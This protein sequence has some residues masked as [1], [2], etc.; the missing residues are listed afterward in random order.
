MRICW[1]IAVAMVVT[2]MGRPPQRTLLRRSLG[3]EGNNK[4]KPARSSIRLV[5]EIPVI[6]A[7]DPKHSHYIQNSANDPIEQSSSCP[8]RRERDQVHHSKSNLL[9]QD[10]F[11]AHFRCYGC[12]THFTTNR[13]CVIRFVQL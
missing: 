10:R 12:L 9:F 4:L 8:D 1:C 6:A 5:G 13:N 3:H 11:T 7:C 2:M